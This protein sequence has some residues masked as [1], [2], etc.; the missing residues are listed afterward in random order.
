MALAARGKRER[1]RWTAVKPSGCD[2]PYVLLICEERW[3]ATAAGRRQ[4]HQR[5][6]EVEGRSQFDFRGR[7]VLLE[8]RTCHQCVGDKC[9]VDPACLD[10]TRVVDPVDNSVLAEIATACEEFSSLFRD[11]LR[12]QNRGHH[13]A[14]RRVTARIGTV[15]ALGIGRD[16]RVHVGI[17]DKGPRALEIPFPSFCDEC[18]IVLGSERP[19]RCLRTIGNSY[20]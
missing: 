15:E 3:C 8:L 10:I 7:K 12:K 4:R 14:E 6:L 19:A 5:S 1:R 13:I 17:V 11:H 2:R 20:L 16:G 9:A 18:G